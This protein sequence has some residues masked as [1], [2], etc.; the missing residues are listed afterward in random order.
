LDEDCS[1]LFGGRKQVKKQLEE[2]TETNE[3]NVNNVRFEAS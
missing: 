3:D 1:K 2:P